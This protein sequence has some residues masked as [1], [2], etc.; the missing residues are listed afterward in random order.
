MESSDSG[1]IRNVA[2]SAVAEGRWLRW[3]LYLHVA[4]V[5]VCVMCSLTDRGLFISEAVSQFLFQT[6]EFLIWP[7]CLAWIA[8][9]AVVVFV[10]ARGRSSTGRALSVLLVEAALCV[11]Q[12]YALLPLVS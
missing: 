11:V 8:C 2:S 1:Q 3:C 9:P 7:A 12:L 10:I 6:L 5:I 4:A